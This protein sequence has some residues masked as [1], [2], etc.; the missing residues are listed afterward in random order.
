MR[1]QLSFLERG[2]GDA[3]AARLAVGL[4]LLLLLV[5]GGATIAGRQTEVVPAGMAG[6]RPN[7]IVIM[8]DDM[9][10]SDLGSFGS[11]I[12]TPNLDQLAAGGIRFTQFYNAARCVPTRASLLTGLYSHQAGIGHMLGR[13]ANG[14]YYGDLSRNAITLAEG[15]GAAGYGTYMAG[16][17]HLTPWSP[18]APNVISNGPTGRGFNRFYGI[19]QSIR[20]FY[21]PPSLMEDGSVLPTPQGD[22]HFTDAVTEHATTYIREHQE[23][24][25]YFVYVAYA[26]PHFPLHARE[27]DIARY[28]GQFKAGWDILKS[29]RHANMVA[30]GLI[31]P[32]WPLPQRDP[33]ELPWD[34]INPA[35]RDWFDE[36]MAVYAAMIEQMD[37]GVGAI[38][39]EVRARGDLDNT[40]IVFLSDNGGSAEEIDST[41]GTAGGFPK[42]TRSGQIVRLGND[43]KI[44]PGPE[45]T[46][47][48]YGLEWAGLSNTPFRRYKSFVH[49]GG[50]AAPLIVSWPGRIVPGLTHEQGHVIDFMPTLLEVAGA[51]YPTQYKGNTIRPVEG[52]SLLPVL[53]GGTR[54]PVAYGWEHEG[55]R[56]VRDSDWKLVS[57]YPQSWELYDM[58]EDRLETH[59]LAKAMPQKAADMAK[60]YGSWASRVGVKTWFGAQTPIGWKDPTWYTV[61]NTF[62][63]TAITTPVNNATVSKNKMLTIMASASDNV[64]VTRVEFYV[65]GTRKCTD[66]A[67]L[68]SCAWW[69]PN[70][71]NASYKLHSKAFD[72]I[73]NA[74]QST[75]VNV[76]AK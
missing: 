54:P 73:G 23:G 31:D 11:S 17:W 30:L 57:R 4:V 48:S 32:A 29:E 15:L 3:R 47:A 58:R 26:A 53:Q 40:L 9:G 62:P 60:L 71:A 43:P 21:N 8:A 42:K 45:D 56:A 59:D 66:T 12:Y 63:V 74:A 38:V 70:V 50:I 16:K 22:Y 76:T 55:N 28:R 75:I 2:R 35:Y 14:L 61:D 49:E 5:T 44:N 25:P 72:N 20:S 13:S 39:D 1:V 6:T 34:S 64:R 37:R 46:Y 33:Q 19:I 18:G 51:P 68:Y 41:G 69:V 24:K 67:A 36:R 65:N 7:I 10:Y 27:F 52:R